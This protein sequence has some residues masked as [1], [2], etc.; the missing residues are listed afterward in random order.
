M[1][2]DARFVPDRIKGPFHKTVKIAQVEQ[3]PWSQEG[4]TAK[5]CPTAAANYKCLCVQSVLLQEDGFR[6]QFSGF[7]YRP[8]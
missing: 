1:L 7:R 3:M 4:N 2:I 5:P 8:K 6:I